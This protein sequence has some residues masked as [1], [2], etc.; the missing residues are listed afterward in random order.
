MFKFILGGNV[1]DLFFKFIIF[2]VIRNFCSL[3]TTC[4]VLLNYY[5][6]LLWSI[7]PVLFMI[8]LT[9]DSFVDYMAI[10]CRFLYIND[11]P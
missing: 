1:Y 5:K 3:F 7:K 11:F 4:L 9:I 6:S 8:L 10:C 2:C